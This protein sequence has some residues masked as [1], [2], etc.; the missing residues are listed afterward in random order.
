MIMH[1]S[2]ERVPARYRS[3]ER[4]LGPSVALPDG[5]RRALE[6]LRKNAAELGSGA[7]SLED[8]ARAAGSTPRD[9]SRAF[10][11]T[12][13]LRPLEVALLL[14]L[15][16]SLRLLEHTALPIAEVAALCGF[17][18]AP[19]YLKVFWSAFSMTPLDYRE[20]RAQGRVRRLRST[21]LAGLI[22]QRVIKTNA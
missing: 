19:H 1:S 15:D 16:R 12:L 18:G 10:R 7:L 5:V 21:S 11:E 4:A 9:L 3:V 2:P 6:V 22:A 13:G 14:R 8:L 20:D 17:L